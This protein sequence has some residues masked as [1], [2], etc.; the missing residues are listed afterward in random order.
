MRHCVSKS[1]KT[2]ET[3]SRQ[4]LYWNLKV[5]YRMEEVISYKQYSGVICFKINKL[6]V[7]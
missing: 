6:E 1:W 3:D 2:E 7:T 4:S 5:G